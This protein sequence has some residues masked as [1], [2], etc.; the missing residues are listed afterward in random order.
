MSSSIFNPTMS[1]YIP[2]VYANITES[3]IINVFENKIRFGKIRSVNIEKI[4]HTKNNYSAVIHFES[5]NETIVTT[6]FQTRIFKQGFARVVHDDP[7]FWIVVENN[8]QI[9]YPEKRVLEV[10]GTTSDAEADIFNPIEDQKFKSQE[11]FELING[12]VYNMKNIINN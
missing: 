9:V 5:W 12:I 1:L 7:W 4:H 8:P 6:N 2:R 11:L 3:F 10:Q